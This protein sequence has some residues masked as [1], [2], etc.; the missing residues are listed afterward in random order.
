MGVL[1]TFLRDA[2]VNYVNAERLAE[3]RN[4][5]VVR[6]T[7]TT[8]A[9]Y[10]SLVGV[11]LSG[12]GQT[13]ELDGTLFGEGDPRVVRI[14]GFRLEFRP[15]GQLLFVENRDVP[16]VVGK[17]GTL[18]ADAGINIADIH[19][20]RTDRVDASGEREALAML[21]VDQELPDELVDRL[22]ELGLVRSARRVDLTRK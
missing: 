13:V 4:L 7:H 2:V 11:T 20:A 10:P 3:A 8:A 6:A 22:I 16:G 1:S 17:V 18:L 19:L 12:G 5:E 15:E 14:G 21:R 9:D